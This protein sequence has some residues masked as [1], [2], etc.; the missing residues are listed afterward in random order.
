MPRPAG[1][2]LDDDNDDGRGD[3]HAAKVGIC[4]LPVKCVHAL[5]I[6]FT[7]APLPRQVQAPTNRSLAAHLRPV[8]RA[9][10]YAT[11]PHRRHPRRRARRG[12]RARRYG[13]R[14]GQ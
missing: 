5:M 4:E 14:R 9:A 12:D 1:D 11:S 13:P 2:E 8:D 6:G 3:A 10:A 7:A